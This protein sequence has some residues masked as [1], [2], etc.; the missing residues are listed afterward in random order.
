[1]DIFH[2]GMASKRFYFTMFKYVRPHIRYVVIMPNMTL[3]F[4]PE[5]KRRMDAHPHVKWSNA[6]RTI[7]EQKLN[8]FEEAERLS[9]KGGL[10][11]K[12]VDPIV[13]KINQAMGKRAKDLLHE[14]NH[15]R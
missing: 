10:T 8:D 11:Q 15:R 4:P 13:E 12:D 9:K 14:T 6:V 5:T 3:S 1:M 2:G 7:I